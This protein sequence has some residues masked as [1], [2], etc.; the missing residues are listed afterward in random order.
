MKNNKARKETAISDSFLKAA[1]S[2]I[3]S[4]KILLKNKEYSNSLYH[5]QQAIE[6]TQSYA[7]LKRP[8]YLQA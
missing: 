1:I 6:N 8:F 3:N 4:A 2:D 5:S 7:C